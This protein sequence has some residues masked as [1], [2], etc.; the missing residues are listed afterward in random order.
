MNNNS[1]SNRNRNESTPMNIDSNYY[2]NTNNHTDIK[3]MIDI[4]KRGNS[5]QVK[6]L[7]REEDGVLQRF[8]SSGNMNMISRILEFNTNINKK[9]SMSMTPLHIAAMSS[10]G[11]MVKFLIRKGAN[12]NTKSSFNMTPLHFAVSSFESV[13]YLV[14][15]GASI[16]VKNND[17]CTPLDVALTKNVRDHPDIIKS[18]LLL[19]NK[20]ANINCITHSKFTESSFD[21][22]KTTHRQVFEK[23]TCMIIKNERSLKALTVFLGFLLKKYNDQKHMKFIVKVFRDAGVLSMKQ[24]NG[25]KS[26]SIIDLLF[27]YLPT[28]FIDFSVQKRMLCNL[29]ETNSI[30]LTDA[31][32]P[33]HILVVAVN[34]CY[35]SKTFNS[36]RKLTKIVDYIK[37]KGYDINERLDIEGIHNFTRKTPIQLLEEDINSNLGEKWENTKNS[38]KFLMDLHSIMVSR[39]AL[40]TSGRRR[41]REGITKTPKMRNYITR[42]TTPIYQ[43]VQNARRQMSKNKKIIPKD[44]K[45]L[46]LVNRYMS[47]LF[48]NHGTRAP[49]IPREFTVQNEWNRGWGAMQNKRPRYLYR[50]IHKPLS[51]ILMKNGQL[52]DN[53]YIAF[54]RSLRTA[55]EFANNQS[56]N[57]NINRFVIDP[58]K[59]LV[60]RLSVNS[61]PQGTPWV[62]FK[63]ST[64]H[65][66]RN[67]YKSDIEEKEVLLPP[68]TLRLRSNVPENL[69]NNI[70]RIPVFDVD[71]IPDMSSTSLT[72]KRM[73]RKTKGIERNKQNSIT[74][75]LS[76]NTDIKK[77][78][79]TSTKSSIEKKQKG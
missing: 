42:W 6:K 32:H 52:K 60:M 70:H 77:R 47:Q 27:L 25:E 18:L 51:K 46:Y 36:S 53:A 64:K 31:L 19:L 34:R 71:F 72:G 76:K 67:V 14:D 37:S 13:R 48:R 45:E 38:L 21:L 39:G 1:N 55:S 3:N 78:R 58:S 44:D 62:W 66:D 2:S 75:R 9:D 57:D 69:T 4:I 68:G 22:D 15:A 65:M 33:F 74:S 59:G 7:L 40:T 17:G 73:Y 28:K 50:G 63:A 49:V 41:L 20:G 43:N 12:V 54:S 23:I 29:F 16:N 35:T 30:R 61:I 24:G 11:N 5:T 26:V 79:Y 56:N 10:R 8:A